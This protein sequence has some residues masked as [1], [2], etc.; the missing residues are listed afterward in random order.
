MRRLVKVACAVADPNNQNL[1]TFNDVTEHVRS[2]D[3]HLAASRISGTSPAGKLSKTFRQSD[4]ALTNPLRCKRI[5]PFD[6][7]YN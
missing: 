6:V 5:E 1:L 2:N 3:G 7:S 4:Q